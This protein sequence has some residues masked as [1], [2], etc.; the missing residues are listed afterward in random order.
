MILLI[1]V[2]LI[3]I[4]VT[5]IAPAQGKRGKTGSTS[6]VCVARVANSS[7][8]PVA[9]DQVQSELIKN[10]QQEKLNAFAVPTMTTL[11]SRLDL[12][13]PNQNA[14]RAIKCDFMLLAEVAV[15]G[16]TPE[17]R[18]SQS[19]VIKFA[20]F[21]KQKSLSLQN[22]VTASPNLSS[23]ETASAL[24]SMSQQLARKVVVKK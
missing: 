21:D 14:L 2:V 1:E 12:S 16:T 20:L 5:H 9:V 15:N 3:S 19:I 17:K 6:K 18:E 11:A 13:V 24:R 4:C 8:Q 23:A 7:G 10:L 22:S